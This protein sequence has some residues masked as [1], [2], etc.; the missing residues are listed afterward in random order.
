MNGG[1]LYTDVSGNLPELSSMTNFVLELTGQLES[2][3][4]AVSKISKAADRVVA[5]ERHKIQKLRESYKRHGEYLS[6]SDEEDEE[7]EDDEEGEAPAAGDQRATREKVLRVQSKKERWQSKEIQK[8]QQQQ[9]QEHTDTEP[10][11][12]P[13]DTS[14]SISRENLNLRIELQRLEVLETRMTEVISRFEVATGNVRDGS[15]NYMREYGVASQNL[16]DSYESRLNLEK[17]TQQLLLDTRRRMTEELS[18]LIG[19]VG[20]SSML[21]GNDI[22]QRFDDSNSFMK[23][24]TQNDIQ[25]GNVNILDT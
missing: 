11:E 17:Q 18:S 23:Y 2:N 14:A 3:R 7:D 13:K 12:E 21:M 19:I 20:Q 6:S 16:V 5:Q 8:R 9:Q 4:E 25:N 22:K 15:Q 10:E 1:A 24:S